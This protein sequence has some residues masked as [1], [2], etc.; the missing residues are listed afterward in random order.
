MT[1]GDQT[2][3]QLLSDSSRRSCHK[4][5]HHQLLD[6][7]LPAPHKT[8][9][10]PRLW[11]LRAPRH[12][13][14]GARVAMPGY[15]R[16]RGYQIRVG[17]EF[18]AEALPPYEAHVFGRPASARQAG[19]IRWHCRAWASRSS[20]P[21]FNRPG[22]G[23]VVDPAEAPL[24]VV[25]DHAYVLHERLHA[26]GPDEAVPLRLQLLGERFRLRRRLGQVGDGPGCPLAGD[27]VGMITSLLI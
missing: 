2:R 16:W 4:D 19:R 9:W 7:G 27:L 23:A 14:A 20:R 3:H 1:R 18:R 21:I 25:V 17:S 6:R 12:R 22:R 26:R 10:R 24:D 11:H 13:K 8:R 15:E 5:P